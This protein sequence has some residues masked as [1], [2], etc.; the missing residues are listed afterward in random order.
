MKFIDEYRQGEIARRLTRQIARL[1]DRR[2]CLQANKKRYD[3]RLHLFAAL[4][5]G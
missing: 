3:K 1:T 4:R 2:D 5:S